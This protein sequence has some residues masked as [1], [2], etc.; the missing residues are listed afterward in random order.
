MRDRA[1]VREGRND[2]DVDQGVGQV[3]RQVQRRR[4]HEGRLLI[5]TVP[6]SKDRA[7]TGQMDGPDA[8]LARCAWPAL[9]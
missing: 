3:L 7:L 2:P 1:E 4:E 5:G 6:G 8:G 9:L